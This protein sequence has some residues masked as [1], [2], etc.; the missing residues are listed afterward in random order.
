MTPDSGRT[1]RRLAATQGVYYLTTGAWSLL[2]YPS[3][4][5]ITGPKRED[6]LVKT[7][8]A[9]LAAEG[10]ILIGA[11]VRRAPLSVEAIL[12]AAATA[13]VL[14]GSDAIYAGRGRI[15]PAYWGDAVAEA[16]LLLGWARVLRSRRSSRRGS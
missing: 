8:G 13:G 11:A 5:V 9:L 12:M 7:V 4:E 6:W 10:A 2:H 16:A 15:G 14:G 3:F 1:E